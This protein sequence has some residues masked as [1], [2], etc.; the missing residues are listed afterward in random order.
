V[1]APSRARK[2][3]KPGTVIYS[4]VRPYLKNIAVIEQEYSPKPI[5][6]TAFAIIAP[7]A[8]LEANFI[9]NYLRCPDFVE[10][11][12]SQM[13]GVAYP[14]I[15]DAKFF[16]S[17]F[18]LP[19]LTEQKRII[20]KVDELMSLCDELEATQNTHNNLKRDCVASTLHHLSEAT[21]NQEIKSNWSIL[22]GNFNNWFD[23]LETVKKLRAS[24]LQLAVQGKL[25]EQDPDDE[26]ASVLLKKI[27]TEKELLITE[28]LIKKSRSTPII[29]NNTNQPPN[30]IEG[31][32]SSIS[33][34]ASGYGFPKKYQGNTGLDI[35]FAKVSDMNRQGNERFIL[36]TANTVSE[37]DLKQMRASALPIGTII[38]PKIGGAIAT[39]KRR[40]LQKPTCIDNNCLGVTPILCD[41]NWVFYLL[42]S[43]KMEKYQ[44]GTSV[45]ALS[46]KTLDEL[47][48]GIPPLAEQK[49]IVAK[50]DELMAICDQ[51]EAQIKTSQTLN[52]NLMASLS[53]HMTDTNSQKVDHV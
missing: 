47:T 43:W 30:W 4:T 46:Q 34:W 32:L 40:I 33:E 23:D 29:I 5:A 25:V 6:S 42:L 14:A 13:K 18:P 9:K 52:Q 26:P 7:F 11:V 10:Y 39:N 1:D 44:S 51:L 21:D 16:A 38:F 19:P 24:I 12:E 41:V 37:A 45:P 15:N 27:A 8:E 17:P 22:H 49:R 50:V 35:L 36:E 28:G 20:A 31:N 53:H 3:V 48:F 2:L